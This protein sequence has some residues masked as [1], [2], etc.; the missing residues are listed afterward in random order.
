MR[1]KSNK[2]ATKKMNERRERDQYVK[3]LYFIDSEMK[4]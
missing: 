2:I 1:D 4:Y 3:I